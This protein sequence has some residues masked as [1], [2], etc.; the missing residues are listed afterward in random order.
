MPSKKSSTKDVKRGRTEP[1]FK[2]LEGIKDALEQELL[3]EGQA[4]ALRD[5]ILG[6]DT[7]E[8]PKLEGG[9]T[10]NG[11][12]AEE[13]ARRHLRRIVT[14]HIGTV[15]SPM[16]SKVVWDE[17]FGTYSSNI[18]RQTLTT[19]LGGNK[20]RKMVFGLFREAGPGKTPECLATQSELGALAREMVFQLLVPVAAK[21]AGEQAAAEDKRV[22][23]EA[24]VDTVTAYCEKDML[25]SEDTLIVPAVG[26]WVNFRNT[27]LTKTQTKPTD[28]QPKTPKTQ[29]KPKPDGRPKYGP[30]P[31]VQ[32]TDPA[33]SSSGFRCHKCNMLGHYRRDCPN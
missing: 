17:C 27:G 33:V 2:T 11:L 21:V 15:E 16:I 31:K 14:T 23:R 1:D 8:K 30:S 26:H 12:S 32:D 9:E 24:I 22:N 25:S 7:H 29:P 18:L 6:I 28:T 5:K 3:D 20:A 13:K 10:G 19:H 4:K